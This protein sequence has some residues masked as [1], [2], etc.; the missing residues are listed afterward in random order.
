MARVYDAKTLSYFVHNIEYHILI[1]P[2]GTDCI[3]FIK[4]KKK[5][6]YVEINKIIEACTTIKYTHSV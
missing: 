1:V 5:N 2:K 4:K 6:V 3:Y